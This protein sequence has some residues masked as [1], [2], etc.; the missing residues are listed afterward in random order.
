MGDDCISPKTIHFNSG[1]GYMSFSFG[2][3]VVMAAI[4]I[5]GLRRT[6]LTRKRKKAALNTANE[7]KLYSLVHLPSVG[8]NG[9]YKLNNNVLGL[10]QIS[11]VQ[12]GLYY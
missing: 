1:L 3:A 8:Q 5:Y 6:L 4:G 12:H 2:G 7:E 9:I 11:E 10:N